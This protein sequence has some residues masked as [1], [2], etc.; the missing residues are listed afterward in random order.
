[1]TEYQ[2][3]SV[4]EEDKKWFKEFLELKWR[5]KVNESE[6]IRKAMKEYYENHKDGNDQTTLDSPVICT[7][8]FF[9]GPKVIQKYFL[10][11]L[12]NEFDSHRF[13]LCEWN[14]A[15]KMRYGQSAI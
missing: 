11:C 10:K 4:P 1:M 3:F 13:K 14:H 9:R 8:A 2:T 12:D 7:P 6:L 15:F 5:D